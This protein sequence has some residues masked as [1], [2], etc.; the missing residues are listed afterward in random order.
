MQDYRSNQVHEYGRIPVPDYCGIQ[1]ADYPCNPEDQAPE[2]DPPSTGQASSPCR[3]ADS[4]LPK[5]ILL[6]G[7]NESA[8]CRCKLGRVW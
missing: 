6:V 4:R 8:R 3:S 2:P 5:R 7:N 1:G